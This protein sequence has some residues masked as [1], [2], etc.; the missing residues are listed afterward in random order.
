M[1]LITR[2]SEKFNSPLKAEM[3]GR[4]FRL[5]Q[6]RGKLKLRTT[7]PHELSSANLETREFCTGFGQKCFASW[8]NR[9]ISRFEHEQAT[10]RA[11]VLAMYRLCL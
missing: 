5:I 9:R 6:K 1:S 8:N 2:S 4:S 3:F 7:K 10:S 11:L